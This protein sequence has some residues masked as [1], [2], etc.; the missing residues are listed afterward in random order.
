M[1]IKLKTQSLDDWELNLFESYS[2]LPIIIG[3]TMI[4]GAYN[5]DFEMTDNIWHQL[6]EE[7]K[8]KIYKY[9]WKKM[10]KSMLITVTDITAYSFGFGYNTKLKD[11]ITMEEISKNFDENK[12]IN[13][14]TP[15]C[16]FPDSSM[17]VYFQYLGEVYAEVELDELV[18][19]SDEENSYQHSIIPQIMAASN[20]RKRRENKTVKLEQIYNEQL[21]VKNIVNKNIDELSKEDVQ[22][23]LDNFLLIDNLKYLLEVIKKSKN[24][25]IVISDKLK[26]GLEHWLR[27]IQIKIKREEDE[28][29][30]QEIKE[31]LKEQ[32]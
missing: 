21:T 18:A 26:D 16:D 22:K 8:K 15:A 23:I 3:R 12:K 7:Y 4:F 24:F 6:P 27:D 11:S 20:Y 2:T 5:V 10:I 28:K 17:S 1:K 29:I 19:I 32:L 13:F 25:E 9:N 30:Y 14:L 31:I